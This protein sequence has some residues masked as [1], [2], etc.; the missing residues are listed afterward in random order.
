[1]IEREVEQRIGEVD[2]SWADEARERLAE[3]LE[4]LEAY[5]AELAMREAPEGEEGEAAP[6]EEGPQHVPEPEP[7]PAPVDEASPSPP[8]T[9]APVDLGDFRAGGGRILDFLRMHAIP[10]TPREAIDQTAWR[11]STPKEE[12]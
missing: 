4:I 3:E 10:E 9:P 12:K 5:Y 11:K 2:Q 8:D 6:A 7:V 1:M